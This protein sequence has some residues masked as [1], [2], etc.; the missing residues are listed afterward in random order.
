MFCRTLQSKNP[1]LNSTR[2]T[3]METTAII[4]KDIN[5]KEINTIDECNTNVFFT[6]MVP[7]ILHNWALSDNVLTIAT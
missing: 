4:K 7:T 6:T 1:I 5:Q 3:E 2:G